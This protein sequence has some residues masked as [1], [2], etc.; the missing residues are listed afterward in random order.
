[1]GHGYHPPCNVAENNNN[2]NTRSTHSPILTNIIIE[3]VHY[4][5]HN[6]P[7]RAFFN[8]HLCTDH[9]LVPQQIELWHDQL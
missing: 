7:D 2:N 6:V 8:Q 1:M 4:V 9:V 3:A 5:Y